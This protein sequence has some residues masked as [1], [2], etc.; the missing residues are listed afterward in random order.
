MKDDG[1]FED[2][3]GEN[4]IALNLFFE[5]CDGFKFSDAANVFHKLNG[6]RN[7]QKIFFETKTVRFKSE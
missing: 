5:R 6:N 4:N 3:F 1:V 7:M 2:F